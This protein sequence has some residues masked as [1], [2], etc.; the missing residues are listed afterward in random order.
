MRRE[1]TAQPDGWSCDAEYMCQL[2]RDRSRGRQLRQL[3]KERRGSPV[4]GEDLDCPC[5]QP[6]TAIAPAPAAK[7]L[8]RRSGVCL[9]CECGEERGGLV[10]C[11]ILA[12]PTAIAGT[13]Y[14]LVPPC[15]CQALLLA[16]GPCPHPEGDRFV[17]AGVNLGKAFKG[18]SK[19]D[20]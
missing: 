5:G 18:S 6:L 12:R 4:G 13:L 9:A 3:L 2:C 15:R 10:V 19:D 20:L 11:G 17:A 8:A 16:G 14:E 7:T 1:P